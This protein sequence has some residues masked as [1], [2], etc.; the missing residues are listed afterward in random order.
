MVTLEEVL[1]LGLG[2][3][4]TEISIKK[5]HKTEEKENVKTDVGMACQKYA[6]YTKFLV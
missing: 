3:N 5:A 2:V 1:F 6:N 4:V